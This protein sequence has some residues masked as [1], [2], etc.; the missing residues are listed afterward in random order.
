MGSGLPQEF[1][2]SK[3]PTMQLANNTM[4]LLEKGIIKK[5]DMD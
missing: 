3:N 2:K 5:W 4:R 1:K